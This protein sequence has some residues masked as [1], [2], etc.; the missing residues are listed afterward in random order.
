MHSI[1]DRFKKEMQHDLDIIEKDTYHTYI[2]SDYEETD[3]EEEFV[4]NNY[5]KTQITNNY[6]GNCDSK[7]ATNKDNVEQ[8]EIKNHFY[9]Y[10]F[11]KLIKLVFKKGS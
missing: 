5:C 8:G 6:N 9:F 7:T 1:L 10:F 3:D 11:F 4:I 2:E